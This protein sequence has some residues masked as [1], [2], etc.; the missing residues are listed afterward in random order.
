MV[1]IGE[2]KGWERRDKKKKKTRGSDSGRGKLLKTYI[3]E[4]I[5]YR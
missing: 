4:V 1:G 5:H 3:L 2:I